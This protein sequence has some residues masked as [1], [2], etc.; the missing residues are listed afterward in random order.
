MY[1][2][3]L[4]VI[5]KK[6]YDYGVSLLKDLV[7][8]VPG[9]WDARELL[10][11]AEIKKAQQLTG[12]QKIAGQ[13][14]A[15]LAIV[16][17]KLLLSK[18]PREALNLAEEALAS[19][20][21][22]EG[23]HF[24]YEAAMAMDTSYLAIDALE[25]FLENDPNNEKVIEELIVLLEGIEDSNRVLQLR[26]KIVSLRPNDLKAQANLRAAAA[27]ATMAQNAASAAA[28][29]EKSKVT[30]KTNG[31]NL[32]DVSDLERGDRIIRSEEDIK[33]M[34][35]RYE[36]LVEAGQ[37]TIEIHR[38]LG[39][40]YQR[41]NMHEKAIEE[42]NRLAQMQGVLDLVVDKAIERSN[43]ALAE[44]H[45]EEMIATSTPTPEELN[46][47]RKSITNYQIQCGL[48]RIKNYPNDLQVRYDLALLYFELEMIDKALEEFQHAKLNPQ[49]K[50]ISMIYIG[51]CFAIKEQ[52]DM[53]IDIFEEAIKEMPYLDVQK[54]RA[55]YYLGAAY[56]RM[57]K[58]DKAF[59]CFKQIYSANVNYMDVAEKVKKHYDRLRK[60]EEASDT[61]AAPQATATHEAV[62]IQ[63]D[64]NAPE[65]D[66]TFAPT[67]EEIAAGN[68]SS[69]S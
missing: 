13:A 46:E 31:T 35:R 59:E 25:R 53:A 47:A 11:S 15:K 69:R 6:N 17:G 60:K 61:A 43:V 12:F 67:D 10:R 52:Y 41:V 7:K 14:K 5:S 44:Q 16:K 62:D 40:F 51:R 32:P 8:A 42:F 56:E 64:G 30:T 18:D 48:A 54:M 38:K 55:I 33:E 34:I 45:I 4:D 68:E 21:S 2:R 58:A 39:E 65:L 50:L 19:F 57:G 36:K 26:Q 3:A 1:T 9:F 28:A 27:T 22:N 29:A 23:L 20:Y 66:D 49:R 63:E 24:L 37:G